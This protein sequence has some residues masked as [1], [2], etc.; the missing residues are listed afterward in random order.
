MGKVYERAIHKGKNTADKHLEM[1]KLTKIQSTDQD[2]Y[3][4]PFS[5]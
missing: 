4:I 3:K 1:F 2:S 5:F